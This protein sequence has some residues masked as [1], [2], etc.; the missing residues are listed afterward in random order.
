[1]DFIDLKGASGAAYRF[2][3]CAPGAH[4]PPIAG[5]FAWVRRTGSSCE[6][7][8]LGVANNLSNIALQQERQGPEGGRDLFT[9]LN[10]NR[11]TRQAE[12]ADLLEA[13]PAVE[14]VADDL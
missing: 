3:R 2:R 4:H 11:G 1:M 6:L 12:H 5:N 13:H 8:V 7:L 9:R 10:V 14:A